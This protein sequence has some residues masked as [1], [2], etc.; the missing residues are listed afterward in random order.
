M[1][2]KENQKRRKVLTIVALATGVVVIAVVVT[3]SLYL[4]KAKQFALKKLT[5]AVQQHMGA[6]YRFD[7]EDMHVRLLGGEVWVT[8]VSVMP[9]SVVLD[10]LTRAGAAPHALYSVRTDAIRVYVNHPYRNLRRDILD[11]RRLEVVR[12]RVEILRDSTV[13]QPAVNRPQE[14]RSPFKNI[15]VHSIGIRDG[16]FS[17]DRP[18]GEDT[19]RHRLEGIALRVE[20]LVIDSVLNLREFRLPALD[21]VRAEVVNTFHS[22]VGEALRL[23]IRHAAVDLAARR[24]T[25][26]SL[27]LLPVY[28]KRDFTRLTRKKTDWI[29]VRIPQLTLAGL[30]FRRLTAREAFTADTLAIRGLEVESYKNRQ[31]PVPPREKPLFH[32]MLQQAG[33]PVAIGTVLVTDARATYEELPVKGDE[34]GMIFLSNIDARIDSLTNVPGS[35]DY[36][37][38]TATAALMGRGALKLDLRFPVEEQ[39]QHFEVRGTLHEVDI[40]QFNPMIRPLAHMS[41]RSGRVNRLDFTAGGNDLHGAV[42]MR[43]QYDSLKVEVL[44]KAGLRS[45]GG[46]MLVNDLVLA[47]SN[48]LPGKEIRTVHATAERDPYRSHINYLWR[49]CFAGIKESAGL[50]EKKQAQFTQI[51]SQIEQIKEN[52]ARLKRQRK[53]KN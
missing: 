34:P 13:R 15:T 46:T 35:S 33:M 51:K 37:T 5:D 48:P 20:K 16:S 23:K 7:V 31:T 40:E 38:L 12:P 44:N 49:I 24:L 39:N 36:Y 52:F 28:E 10:S 8:G 6:V 1:V 50:T 43:F 17:Y 4:G 2:S 47:A 19:V 27:E 3:A 22:P 11:I 18:R 29:C 42:E 45:W 30:D 26:D 21:N 41:V 14:F 9:D 32:R 53:E 25:L